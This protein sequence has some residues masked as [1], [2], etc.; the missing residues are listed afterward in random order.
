MAVRAVGINATSPIAGILTQGSVEIA[1]AIYERLDIDSLISDSPEVASIL[2]ANVLEVE[3]LIKGYPEIG[4]ISSVTPEISDVLQLA[5]P[6]NKIIFD[7]ANVID[8]FGISYQKHQQDSMYTAETLNIEFEKL[9]TDI[10][11]VIDINTLAITK[12][13]LDFATVLEATKTYISKSL[14]DYFTATDQVVL[15]TIQTSVDD[16]GIYDILLMSIGFNKHFEDS[17]IVDDIIGI[18]KHFEGMGYSNAQIQDFL[19]TA[20]SKALFDNTA[21]TDTCIIDTSKV[22][23]EYINLVENTTV[24]STKQTIDNIFVN[25]TVDILFVY[26]S[27]SLFNGGLFN[28]STFG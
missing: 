7:I 28:R 16:V 21:I 13:F 20:V 15:S 27:T 23:Y 10:A 12:K 17:I 1:S 22:Y 5:S 11:N 6:R 9:Y 8:E 26:G 2:S 25:D 4:T 18:D 14:V 19:E 3:K 24:S